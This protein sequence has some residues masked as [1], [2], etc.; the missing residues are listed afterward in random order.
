M[1][2]SKL[3]CDLK[4]LVYGKD[5]IETSTSKSF[6]YYLSIPVNCHGEKWSV[7]LPQRTD[8]LEIV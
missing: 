8:K 4:L 1:Q 6:L 3:G 5:C 2:K 7:L